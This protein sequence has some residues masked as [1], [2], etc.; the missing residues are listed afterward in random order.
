MLRPAEPH[1]LE[2]VRRWR[3]HPEVRAQFL[4]RD[5][6]TP[7]GH[8]AW[9]SRVAADPTRRVLIFEHEGAPAGAVTFQDH[10]PGRGHRR[11]GLLPR[12]RRPAPRNAL[13]RGLD[14]PRTGRHPLRPRRPAPHRPRRPH[15]RHQQTGARAPPPQRLRRG[16]VP[17]L[18][19]RHRR[20]PHPRPLAR[21]ALLTTAEETPARPP[22]EAA[23]IAR[24][25]RPPRKPKALRAR[26][27]LC[28]WLPPQNSRCP[29]IALRS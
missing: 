25:T 1:D 14:R 2:P 15:P 17:A 19:H 11:M 13:F 16:P 24:R 28:A 9:W 23:D 6:I 27:S 8:R 26:Y 29:D 5:V 7:E 18:H 10:D 22:T 20:H 12:H 21:T 4:F 3:N